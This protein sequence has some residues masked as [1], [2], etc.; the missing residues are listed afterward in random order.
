[1]WHVSTK[2]ITYGNSKTPLDRRQ[3]CRKI[4]GS[5]VGN[6]VGEPSRRWP[7]GRGYRVHSVSSSTGEGARCRG[8][9]LAQI[10]KPTEGEP[11]AVSVAPIEDLAAMTAC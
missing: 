11:G 5:N 7:L 8:A 9:T 1:M 6:P 2:P 4:G 10:G 3:Q